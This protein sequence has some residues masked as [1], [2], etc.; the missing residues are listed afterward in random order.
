MKLKILVE[1]EYNELLALTEADVRS[2]AGQRLEGKAWDLSV[3]EATSRAS[4]KGNMMMH[5]LFEATFARAVSLEIMKGW[6][7]A[8]PSYFSVRRVE[9]VRD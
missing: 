6:L 2:W 7:S 3:L 9:Y 1:L 4:R 5:F 8:P